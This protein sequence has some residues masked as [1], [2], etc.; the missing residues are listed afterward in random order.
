MY[1]SGF[2]AMYDDEDFLDITGYNL[3]AEWRRGPFEARGEAILLRQEF[4]NEDR[5][6]T[7]NRPGYY[8]QVARRWA[9]FEPVIRWAQLLDTEVDGATAREGYDQLAVGLDYWISPSVPV[10]VAWE[11]N[12]DRDD[13][14]LFQ[15]AFGF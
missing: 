3:A 6:D 15:W 9:D 10:K 2:H 11:A 8:V 14:F 1:L 7:A 4:V 12:M 13:R 5:Y